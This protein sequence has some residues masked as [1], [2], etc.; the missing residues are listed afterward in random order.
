MG[1]FWYD[2]DD[3]MIYGDIVVTSTPPSTLLMEFDYWC[4]LDYGYDFVYVEVANSPAEHYN[5]WDIVAA[6]NIDSYV[7]P[8]AD[9]DGWI[10]DEVVDLAATTFLLEEEIEVRL[11]L[12]SDGGWEFRGFIVDDMSIPDIGFSDTFDNM[13]NWCVEDYCLGDFWVYDDVAQEWCINFPAADVVNALVWSTEIMDA[14]EAYLSFEYYGSLGSSVAKGQISADGGTTWYTMHEFT[15]T[16]SGTYHF[17]L[18][19]WAGNS[20]LIRFIVEGAGNAGFFC[21]HDL[22][23]SGKEDSSAPVSTIQMS[24]SIN[25]GWYTTP[26]QVTITA[27]DTG[28]GVKEIHYILDGKET[29]VAGAKAT[30]TVSANGAHNL[31]FWAVDNTG[32]VEA[33]HVV[34]EFRID[35][36]SPPTVSITGPEP[37]LYLFGNKLLSMSKVFII[38][39]FDITATAS[40]A[41]S[42]VYRVQFEL[43]GDLIGEDTEAP[44]SVYCAEKHMGAGTITAIAEDFSGNTA[45]DTLDITYYKFL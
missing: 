43:D 34:P 7:Y 23:I 44:F 30:F 10:I 21:V 31:E 32:N 13:N 8:W 16:V 6:Y 25:A 39:A 45:E 29:V 27:T 41:E 15:G 33:R 37:G 24:G 1:I 36:G 40:D 2:I 12:V 11:R 18:T 26:V 28:S 14:Y 22:L 19:P 4:E 35:T 20:V 5:D 38:G 17:D 9:D 42:G 3:L